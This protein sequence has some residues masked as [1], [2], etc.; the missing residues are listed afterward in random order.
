VLFWIQ[1]SAN[2]VAVVLAFV[3]CSFGE[4][5]R[6]LNDFFGAIVVEVPYGNVDL[7]CAC[8]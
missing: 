2:V 4:V 5:P 3:F 7:L 8:S 1:V 6:F